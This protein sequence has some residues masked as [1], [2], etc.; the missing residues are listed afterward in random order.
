MYSKKLKKLS[1]SHNMLSALSASILSGP[2]HLTEL[3]L[4]GNNKITSKEIS[5]LFSDVEMSL[6]RLEINGIFI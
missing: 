6:E 2:Q 5:D 3:E 1:I 4:D